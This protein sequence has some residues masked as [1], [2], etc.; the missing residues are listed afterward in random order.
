[1]LCHTLFV[2]ASAD[3]PAAASEAAEDDALPDSL[4]PSVSMFV[5]IS[6]GQ[7]SVCAIWTRHQAWMRNTV[8][9]V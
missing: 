5:N 8:L 7:H 3:D 1:M 2:G 6:P 9:R 4:P